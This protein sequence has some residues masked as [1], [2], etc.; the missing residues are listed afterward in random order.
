MFELAW[1]GLSYFSPRDEREND[2]CGESL[3]QIRLNA[4]TMG[5]VDK[6]TGMLGR[7]DRFDD[8]GD[9]V[10][11]RQSFYAEQDIVEGGLRRL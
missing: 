7:N 5:C 2:I 3:L 11:V 6:D 8:G 10:H 1:S 9:I 4:E